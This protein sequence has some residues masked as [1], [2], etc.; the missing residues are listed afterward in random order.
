[1]KVSL[2]EDCSIFRSTGPTATTLN[3]CTKELADNNTEIH[4][5]K[6]MIGYCGKSDSP[7]NP[8]FKAMLLGVTM[9][10]YSKAKAFYA[11][12]GRGGTSKLIPIDRKNIFQKAN[13]H[14]RMQMKVECTDLISILLDM[15]RS[16]RFSVS[17]EWTVPF[18]GQGMCAAR[19][20]ACYKVM[21]Q[22]D[23]V[24]RADV[25]FLFFNVNTTWERFQY[26]KWCRS[27]RSEASTW[28]KVM[29]I[30]EKSTRK[31][32]TPQVDED[33]DVIPHLRHPFDPDLNADT[34]TTTDGRPCSEANSA[35]DADTVTETADTEE[36]N[37]SDNDS[38]S[39]EDG[40][41]DGDSD[42]DSGSD[43]GGG[44]GSDSLGQ[45]SDLSGDIYA[46]MNEHY[47]NQPKTSITCA[48]STISPCSQ[49]PASTSTRTHRQS[50]YYQV[51]HSDTDNQK[52]TPNKRRLQP[53]MSDNDSDTEPD[54]P[55][56][57]HVLRSQQT[58]RDVF[59][60]RANVRRRQFKKGR[61]YKLRESSDD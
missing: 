17:P 59:L 22:P 14:A 48:L 51:L 61:L 42:S 58:N 5:V 3:I 40:N 38:V 34:S 21:A 9:K 23:S 11:A 10:A 1:M 30:H 60:Q 52:T 41:G 27:Y 4:T 47:Q 43:S 13:V 29:Q 26:D 35:D 55:P 37:Y 45:S 50:R 25:A 18:M 31:Q 15:C 16:G 36:V 6:G 8:D 54:E 28:A 7:G 33:S 53:R 44:S 12:R 24:T 2:P 19:A 20:Q 57:A 39:S 32:Q 46:V 56:F 49:L